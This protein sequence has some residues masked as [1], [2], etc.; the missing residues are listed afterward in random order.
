MSIGK[1]LPAICA[2]TAVLLASTSA[3]QAGPPS[4]RSILVEARV[5]P[6]Q[7]QGLIA[8]GLDVWSVLPDGVT[9]EMRVSAEELLDLRSRG[10]DPRVVDEDIYATWRQMQAAGPQGGG[11]RDWDQYHDLA[12]T[13]AML[14]SLQAAYPD[15]A[16]LF[17]LGLSVEGRPINGIRISD[18]PA[19][20]DPS[21]EAVFIVGCHHARE[22]ITVEISLYIADRLLGAYASDPTIQELIDH[23]EIWIVPVLNVDGYQYTQVNRWWRKNRRDNGD[24]SFGVDLN[25][26]YSYEWGG[27]GTTPIPSGQTYHGPSPL[28]EPETQAVAAAFQA[29]PF[30]AGMAY[31]SY[32]QYVMSPWGYTSAAPPDSPMMEALIAGMATEIN[33]QHTNP[34]HDYVTGRW[35]VLLYAGSGI[36]VDWVYGEHGVP[37]LIV[38]ARPRPGSGL[39]GFHLAEAQILETCVE[40]YAGLLYMM[41]EVFTLP[42][43]DMNGSRIVDL[44]DVDP[45]VTA[46]VDR[47]AYRLQ[48]PNIVPERVG[49]V[50][51]DGV[52]DGGDIAPFA[53]LLLVP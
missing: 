6:T 26:N 11:S 10:F 45:F 9:L 43:G 27:M 24:G 18:D 4:P 51:Q 42:L 25:R 19:N 50:N 38:E 46:L 44:D 28:S 20:I 40:N 33:L 29:R 17:V 1:I 39:Q 41:D 32:S 14:V 7:A 23:H 21:E 53:N 5:G 35:N 34:L 47:D 52:L 16:A 22:W 31:H 12:S 48:Y 49:D 3:I 2:V 36:F 13:N 8:Q 15:K 30:R 37:G